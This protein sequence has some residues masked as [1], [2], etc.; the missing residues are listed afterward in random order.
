MFY[1]QIVT[2]MFIKQQNHSYELKQK[3]PKYDYEIVIISRNTYTRIGAGLATDTKL[4]GTP[5]VNYYSYTA[6][7]TG[8]LITIPLR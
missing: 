4:L 1:T 8:C 5:N 3:I 6:A 2:K 7:S